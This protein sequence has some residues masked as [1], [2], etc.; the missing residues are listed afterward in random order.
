MADDFVCPMCGGAVSASASECPGCG[1][2]FSPIEMTE[3]PEY[4][5]EPSSEAMV[6]P[7]YIEEP[8]SEVMVE[9]EYIEEPSSEVMVEPEYIEETVT[10]VT[11]E[12]QVADEMEDN[13]SEPGKCG[14]CDSTL[15][16]DGTCPTCSPIEMAADGSDGCPICGSKEFSVESG[17]LVSCSGCGNVYVRDEFEPPSQNWKWKFWIG[18]FFILIGNVGVALGSYVHNVARWSPLGAMYLGYGWIDRFVGIVG[19][20]LFILGLLLFAWSFKRERE[21]QCPSCKVIVRESQLTEFIPEEE[22]ELP[23]SVAVE[24]AL[25]EIGEMAECPSCGASMS[26]F[27]TSCGNCGEVFD[28]EMDFE[29]DTRDATDETGPDRF[30]TA[31]EIDED[32]MVMDSLELEIPQDEMNLDGDGFNALNELES[33]FELSLAEKSTGVACPTCGA[34]VGKGLDTCPGCGEPIPAAKKQKGGV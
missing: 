22:E 26:M 29:K 17:D 28:I 34:T 9:P 23:E 4:I 20:V 18:L 27:D 12:L 6:E 31:S 7:E 2:P 10:E 21:V 15:S 19:I 5:E 14:E 3:E 8:S 1:E 30:L 32:E 16:I 25:E 33:A 11:E 24:S 13:L